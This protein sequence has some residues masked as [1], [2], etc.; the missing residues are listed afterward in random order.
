MNDDCM[1]N[2]IMIYGCWIRSRIIR[3]SRKWF[4]SHQ[5]I[6]SAICTGIKI[7]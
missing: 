6:Q 7:T 1:E 5:D 4:N 3:V 2:G